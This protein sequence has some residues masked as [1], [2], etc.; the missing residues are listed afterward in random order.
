M[1][2]PVIYQF[3][4]VAS[5]SMRC[6][7]SKHMTGEKT[8]LKSNPSTR[9]KPFTTKQAFLWPSNITLKTHQFFMTFW[10]QGWSTSSKTLHFHSTLSS[11][12]Q[13]S[14]QS[15]C[16]AW[17]KWACRTSCGCSHIEVQ[18]GWWNLE[19]N[20]NWKFSSMSCVVMWSC[21]PVH[22]HS[23]LAPS[24]ISFHVWQITFIP[25]IALK[26]ACCW[27]WGQYYKDKT[28]QE[29]HQLDR[30]RYYNTSQI[31]YWRITQS[32]WW[33]L[34]EINMDSSCIPFLN[35]IWDHQMG[36]EKCWL[37]WV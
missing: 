36:G 37:M 17:G 12:W 21:C 24:N 16:S 29:G 19:W 23:A 26:R 9:E 10:S 31:S 35:P 5:A 32:W 8:W 7:V 15:F 3:S 25:F 20:W 30:R 11:S 6:T 2:S 33:E 18:S 1:L 14:C 27:I 4:S 28:S 13:A 34:Q 22:S